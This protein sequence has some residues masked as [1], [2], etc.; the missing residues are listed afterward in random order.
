MFNYPETGK[1]L[2]KIHSQFRYNKKVEICRMGTLLPRKPKMDT[3]LESP[4]QTTGRGSR[5]V[6]GQVRSQLVL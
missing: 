5:L 1:S 4:F 6:M 2:T 3:A